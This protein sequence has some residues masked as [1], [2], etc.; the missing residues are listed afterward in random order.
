MNIKHLPLNTL[1]LKGNFTK[2]D[3]NMWVNQLAEVFYI[4]Y[5]DSY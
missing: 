2:T 1:S 4:N 3:M 5:I